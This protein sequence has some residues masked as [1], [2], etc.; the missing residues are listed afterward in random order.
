MSANPVRASSAH[1]PGSRDSDGVGGLA[2]PGRSP[3]L[4]VEQVADR[5]GTSS[6]WVHERTRTREIPH[7]RHPGS[8]R[9]LFR[10]DWLDAWDAGAELEVVERPR[11]GRIV[12][13]K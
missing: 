2:V 9:C 12:R 4:V 13:P 5:Y 11:G 1:A 3:F 6:R 8:R 10:E 7:L